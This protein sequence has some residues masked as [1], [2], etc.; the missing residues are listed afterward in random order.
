MPSEP[1]TARTSQMAAM[2]LRMSNAAGHTM[3]W[4]CAAAMTALYPAPTAK[5]MTV[6][7]AIQAWK[8]TTRPVRVASRPG[9]WV[10]TVFKVPHEYSEPAIS[11]H[12]TRA[13]AAPS[14][15]PAPMTL[16]TNW[17][18]YRV[19]IDTASRTPPGWV[20]WYHSAE[21]KSTTMPAMSPADT[22]K[23]GRNRFLR[24]S[25]L[26]LAIMILASPL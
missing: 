3:A 23:A 25:A 6:M 22:R 26:M 13:I 21:L 7:I 4:P 17:S 16:L 15:K 9:R 14:G 20:A 2:P 1:F 10:K 18:G 5:M 11:A 12:S 24:H 19:S 8:T